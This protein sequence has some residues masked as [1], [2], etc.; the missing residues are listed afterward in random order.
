MSSVCVC[1]RVCGGIGINLALATIYRGYILLND[2]CL[3]LA[4]YNI[5]TSVNYI[6]VFQFR[7]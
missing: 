7:L 4:I 6:L 2:P 3:K 1:V 5:E